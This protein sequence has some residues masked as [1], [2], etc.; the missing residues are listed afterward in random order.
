MGVRRRKDVDWD[1]YH[2]DTPPAPGPS[3]AWEGGSA[4]EGGVRISEADERF[5]CRKMGLEEGDVVRQDQ[6]ARRSGDFDGWPSSSGGPGTS[7][8]P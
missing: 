2:G 4:D 5:L 3:W 6:T 1:S 8:P 7:V